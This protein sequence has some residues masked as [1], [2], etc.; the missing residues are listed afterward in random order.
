MADPFTILADKIAQFRVQVAGIPEAMMPELV[1][2][3]ASEQGKT[4]GA[5]QDAYG[6]AWPANKDGSKFTFVAVSDVVVGAV[7]RIVFV[8]LKSRVPVLH[9]YGYAKGHVMRS[10]IP[11]KTLPKAWSNRILAIANREF[12]KAV[13]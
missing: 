12:E 11:T 2:A 8:R 3:I 13:S 5:G 4:I 9:H 7:A 6:V 10:V 1:S